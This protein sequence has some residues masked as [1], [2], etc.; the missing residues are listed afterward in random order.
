MGSQHC[1]C[2]ALTPLAMPQISLHSSDQFAS[3]WPHTGVSHFQT[4]FE[5]SGAAARLLPSLTPTQ[6][7]LVVEALGSAGS[8]DAELFGKVADQVRTCP[9][10]PYILPI[11]SPNLPIKY[12]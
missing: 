4:L 12:G 9:I 8:A 1:R 11:K 6:L 10:Q 5:L 3:R 2:V 7:S